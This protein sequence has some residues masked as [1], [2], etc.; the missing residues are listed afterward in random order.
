MA[1]VLVVE[2]EPLSMELVLEIL[3]AAGLEVD[4][5]VNGEEA[6][7]KV[8]AEHY[9]LILM[10]IGLPGMDGVEVL[11][12]IKTNSKYKNMPAIALTSYALKG[13]RE[14]FLEAGFDDYISK[15]IDVPDFMKILKK[16]KKEP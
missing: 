14:R 16:Y 15:P 12:I 1:K 6:I 9:D 2:D 10:D 7:R 4:E 3:K 13:D 11:K 8:E 5:A